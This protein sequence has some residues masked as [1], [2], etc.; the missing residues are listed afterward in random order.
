MTGAT[1]ENAMHVA[2]H[3]PPKKASRTEVNITASTATIRAT[4]GAGLGS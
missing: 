1:K 2:N 4:A 3:D